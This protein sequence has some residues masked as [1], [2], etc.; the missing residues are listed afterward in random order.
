MGLDLNT[1][2]KTT[3]LTQ[4]IQSVKGEASA[5]RLNPA[6][7]SLTE[8]SDS[9][10]IEWFERKSN[11]QTATTTNKGS[12]S[13]SVGKKDEIQRLAKCLHSFEHIAFKGA[14]VENLRSTDNVKQAKGLAHVEHQTDCFNARFRNARMASVCSMLALG[15]VYY[16]ANGNLLPSSS[17]AFKTVDF[18]IPSTNKSQLDIFGDSSPIISASWGTASTSILKQ[19]KRLK[20]GARKLTGYGV[21]EAYYGTNIISYLLANTE[22]GKFYNKV[23]KTIDALESNEIPD[24]YLGIDKWYPADEW[25]FEDQSGTNQSWIG[26]DQVVFC[27]TPSRDWYTLFEGT[28]LI[29]GQY[30]PG[31]DAVAM[32]NSMQQIAGMK[33]WAK[34]LDDPP[35]VIEYAMD[36]WLPVLK[37]P[38]AVFIADTTP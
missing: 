17:G 7:M 32:I 11:R 35:S 29:P 36:D 34:V 9:D 23:G 14:D 1:L 8:Q 5:A 3:Y 33:A 28:S 12:P 19:I 26:D 16:D 37:V 10:T 13:R 15:A 38:N 6:F 22:C 2:L 27:P 25:F 20:S 18:G 24:G 4:A 30:G 31:S 21:N